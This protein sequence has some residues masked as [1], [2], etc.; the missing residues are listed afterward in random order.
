M[1]SKN[2]SSIR[3]KLL[4]DLLAERSR[5]ILPSAPVKLTKIL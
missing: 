1:Y 2:A 4:I 5:D 3:L